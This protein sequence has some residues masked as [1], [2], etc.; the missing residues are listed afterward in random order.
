M[1][2]RSLDVEAEHQEG[3]KPGLLAEIWA[4]KVY[5]LWVILTLYILC[6]WYLSHIPHASSDGSCDVLF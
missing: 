4:T 5:S 2:Y 6:K 3:P 1:A